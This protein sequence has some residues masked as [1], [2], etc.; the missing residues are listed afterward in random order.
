MNQQTAQIENTFDLNDMYNITNNG[1]GGNNSGSTST[2]NTTTIG[3][4]DTNSTSITMGN[5]T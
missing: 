1:Q 2:T 4:I 3:P 5:N